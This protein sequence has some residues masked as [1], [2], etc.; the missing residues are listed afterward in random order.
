LLAALG[1]LAVSAW[2]LLRGR[3][4]LF[5]LIPALFMIVTTLASLVI[6]LRNYVRT[7]NVPLIITDMLMMV[8]AV[9][10]MVLVARIFL[11]HRRPADANPPKVSAS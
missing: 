9:G 11:G 8:L 4:H 10:V 7:G 1:L 2:L 6:L 3:K 5:T